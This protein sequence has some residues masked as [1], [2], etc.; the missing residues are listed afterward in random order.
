VAA[1][2]GF[3]DDER[4]IGNAGGAEDLRERVAG[5]VPRPGGEHLGRRW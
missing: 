4:L 2:P 3:S 1:E 5:A